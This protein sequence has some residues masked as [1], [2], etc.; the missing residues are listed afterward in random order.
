MTCACMTMRPCGWPPGLAATPQLIDYDV[1]SN[2][3]NWL[4]IAGRGT[5]P[6]GGRRFNTLRQAHDYDR[7]GAYRRLWSRP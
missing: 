4:Y 2:Q 3:G 7:D 6:R 1:Y 5:D